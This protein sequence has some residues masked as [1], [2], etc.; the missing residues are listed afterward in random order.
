MGLTI[1][2]YPS[3]VDLDFKLKW[4][5]DSRTEKNHKLIKT[6]GVSNFVKT[7]VVSTTSAIWKLWLMNLVNINPWNIFNRINVIKMSE[8]L[9]T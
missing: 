7:C 6:L 5:L 9:A 1:I 2:S 4:S 8:K 3:G